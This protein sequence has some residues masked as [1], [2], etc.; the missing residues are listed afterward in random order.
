M[1]RNIRYSLSMLLSLAALALVPASPA[2]TQAAESAT[3]MELPAPNKTDGMPLM[4]ALSARHSTK[5]NYSGAALSAQQLSDL[6][7]ATWGVNREDGRR[8]APTAM[9][10]QDVRV[11][12]ALENG[13]WQYDAGHALI[14]VL[15]GDWRSQMG[16][17]SLTLLYAIPQAN[18]WGGA[19]VGSLYQNAALYCA[20]AGLG[21]FVH[22]SGLH[23]LDGKLPLPEGWKVYIIQTVGLLK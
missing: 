12:V 23:A 20:S 9:N 17:G 18:E 2:V 10:R 5:T 16:G 1:I 4:Q 22:V 7:W 19:H 21:N 14:K 6:L 15:D 11:Y 13:V 3:R 8:T